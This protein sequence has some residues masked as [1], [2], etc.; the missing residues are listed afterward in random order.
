MSNNWF[1]MEGS[2]IHAGGIGP[3]E[4]SCFTKVGK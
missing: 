4:K 3:E 1:E 2:G